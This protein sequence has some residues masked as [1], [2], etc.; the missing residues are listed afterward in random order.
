MIATETGLGMGD[1]IGRILSDVEIESSRGSGRRWGR[2]WRVRDKKRKLK[3]TEGQRKA[4][5][6]RKVC[7]REREK[8]G[9]G[10]R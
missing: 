1:G 7:E 8:R 9:E 6:E 2:K 5:G 4:A 10:G 3:E